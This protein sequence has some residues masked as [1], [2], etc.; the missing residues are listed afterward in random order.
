MNYHVLNGDSLAHIFKN[1]G[2]DG[3]VVITCECLIEGDLQG[4]T[5]TE[6]WDTRSTYLAN[7]YPQYGQSYDTDVLAE[8][9]KLLKAPDH[10]E[11]NLWFGY[12]LFCQ[13]N[14]W[15][16]LSLLHDLPI[17]KE[18]YVVFPMYNQTNIWSEFGPATPAD[19]RLS[20]NNKVKFSDA[21]LYLGK[22]LWLAYQHNDL[23]QLE[24]LAGSQSPCFPYLKEVCKAHIDRFPKG[25]K[26]GRPE[27]VIKEII[28]N[29]TTDFYAI[30]NAFFEKEGI[31]GFGDTQLNQIVDKVKARL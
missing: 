27:R 12:E 23:K 31:Y 22:Q 25:N 5:L 18:V 8:F 9:E 21:D 4:D 28:Q 6:F 7:A 10:S 2:I 29:G 13:A 15:F 11:F 16:V 20:Y 3:E 1:A 24:T 26:S 19:L 30:F 14:M 17:A